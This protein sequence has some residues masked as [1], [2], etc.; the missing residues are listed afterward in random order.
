MKIIGLTGGSGS[1]KG[2]AGVFFS[3]FGCAVVDTDKLYHAMIEKDSE[4]SRALI[5]E[6]G[7]GIS[8]E[9]GGVV[10]EKLADIVFSD[11]EK[12]AS[13]NK[14]A[15]SFVRAECDKLIENEKAA[16]REA[17]VIDAPQLF[18]ADMQNICNAT[19]AVISDKSTRV[20]RICAR[21]GISE[22][23]A[24]ARIASQHTDAFFAENCDYLIENNSD[25]AHLLCAVKKVLDKIKGMD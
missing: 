21:D 10:R 2:L 9:N 19:V 8:A 1:G 24:N 20:K 5:A 14:I 12:L 18:E 23:K 22:G 16:G 15:H 17:I 4:C 25:A 3:S 7:D 11:K 6:F 13:L